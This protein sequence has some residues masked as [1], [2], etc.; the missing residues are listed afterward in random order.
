VTAINLDLGGV[1]WWPSRLDR[2]PV[3]DPD[4]NA[5]AALA[6]PRTEEEEPVGV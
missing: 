5:R 4:G 3:V 6:D 2:D 1:I